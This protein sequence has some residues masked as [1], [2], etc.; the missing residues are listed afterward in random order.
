VGAVLSKD[1]ASGRV[2]VREAPSE[3]GAARAGIL[4]GDEVI[5]IDGRPVATMAA[6]EV[7]EALTG[8]VGT[9]VKVTV[10][11]AGVRLEYAV[12]RGPLAGT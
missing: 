8:K 1:N 10:L 5:A 4:P 2:F 12:E 6:A 9:T 11:R 7:H 3:M